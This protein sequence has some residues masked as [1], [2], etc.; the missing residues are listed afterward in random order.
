MDVRRIHQLALALGLAIVLASPVHAARAVP[1]SCWFTTEPVTLHVV[2][3][4]T[5]DTFAITFEPYPTGTTS[6]TT[7]GTYT[8]SPTQAPPLTAYVWRRGGGKTLYKPGSG[9][10]DYHVIAM[11]ATGG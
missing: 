7:D 2:N 8:F 10:N 5:T 11:C 4:P 1:T 3:I 6:W 9:L